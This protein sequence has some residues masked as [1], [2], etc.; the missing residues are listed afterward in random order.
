MHSTPNPIKGEYVMEQLAKKAYEA[1]Q[2]LCKD[3]RWQ[4]YYRPWED[5][6]DITKRAW[7]AAVT[8]VREELT[9]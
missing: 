1:A 7:I 6:Q 3:E 5:T 4:T 9:K 8:C 2:Q